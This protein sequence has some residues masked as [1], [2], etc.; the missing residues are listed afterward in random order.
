MDRLVNKNQAGF[1]RVQDSLV[2][3]NTAFH[4]FSS[5]GRSEV[6]RDDDLSDASQVVE[7]SAQHVVQLSFDSRLELALVLL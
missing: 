6:S 7:E 2:G 3:A 1:Q 5:S 4:G